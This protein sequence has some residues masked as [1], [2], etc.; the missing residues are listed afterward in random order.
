[1]DVISRRLVWKPFSYPSLILLPV[2][3]MAPLFH[4]VGRG[5]SHLFTR[6][7]VIAW[8]IAFCIQYRLLFKC[9]KVWPEKVVPLWHQF[10]LWLLIFILTFESAYG[11]DLF[12]QGGRTWS[13]CVWGVV[14]GIAILSLI[15]WGD[16]L[17]WPIRRFHQAYF[18]VGTTLPILYLFCWTILVNFYHGDPAPLPFIP[19]VNPVEITQ[20][21]LLILTLHWLGR[22]DEWFRDLDLSVPVMK[23]IVGGAGFLLLNAMVARTIHFWVHVPYTGEALYQSILFQAALSIL[24]GV[25]ALVVTLVAT[26]KGSRPAWVAGASI[27]SLVVMKLFV[28][29]LASTGTVARIVSF[30]GVG[31]LMLLIGYFSPLPPARPKEVL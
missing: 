2:M 6:V 20:I 30:L 9:E 25:T 21:F 16:R 13:Y 11:V 1:M 12:L 18:G 7:G 4:L 15:S 8:L 19:V 23:M 26:R 10:T 27:L 5:D 3:V 29:D 14:S 31:S 28:V 17:A 22:Q 24:W